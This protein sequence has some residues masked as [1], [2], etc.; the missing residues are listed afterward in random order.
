MGL[1]RLTQKDETSFMYTDNIPE[2]IMVILLRNDSAFS[3]KLTTD[4]DSVKKWSRNLQKSPNDYMA[5]LHKA[6]ETCSVTYSDSEQQDKKEDVFEIQEDCLVWKQ[7][8][9]DKNVYGRRGKFTLE[10]ISYEEAVKEILNGSV[11]DLDAKSHCMQ[12]LTDDLAAKSNELQEA[13]D[14]AAKCVREKE[15]FEKEV[16]GK[17]VTI[18]NSKKLRIKQLLS[19]QPSGSGE[20]NNAARRILPDTESTSPASKLTKFSNPDSDGYS[21]DTDVDDPGEED[22]D[23][24]EENSRKASTQAQKRKIDR[25][26]KSKTPKRTFDSQDD[27]FNDSLEAELYATDVDNKKQKLGSVSSNTS[28]KKS[29]EISNGTKTSKSKKKSDDSKSEEYFSAHSSEND[30]QNSIINDLF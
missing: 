14:L 20:Q 22:V 24:D 4:S 13:K 26:S 28:S 27:L 16:Y 7:Y 8:F 9:P 30:T 18:I 29:V 1:R 2:Q 17:C 25:N 6:V 5:L 21:S 10:K 19:S 11:G 12:K 15:E 3:V 23:T